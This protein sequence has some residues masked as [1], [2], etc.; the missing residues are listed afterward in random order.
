MSDNMSTTLQFGSGVA[1]AVS[2]GAG[3]SEVKSRCLGLDVG[4]QGNEPGDACYEFGH[5]RLRT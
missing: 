4:E 5:V 1:E 3:F 2:S